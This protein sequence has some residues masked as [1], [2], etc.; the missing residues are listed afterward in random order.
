MQPRPLRP[1]SSILRQRPGRW[2]TALGRDRA[3]VRRDEPQRIRG[4]GLAPGAR[5]EH[6]IF[7]GPRTAQD[8]FVGLLA[9]QSNEARRG[10]LEAIKMSARWILPRPPRR[11]VGDDFAV[12][13]GLGLQAGK[14]AVDGGELGAPA[15]GKICLLD[16][17]A[18]S[19]LFVFGEFD[20]SPDRARKRPDGR[21]FSCDSI[22]RPARAETR[23]CR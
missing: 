22:G 5:Y 6:R 17:G 11:Q 4:R 9:P 13:L 23:R 20:K 14:R 16:I 7:A 1:R 15:G 8:F 21:L 19:V 3:L 2:A 12:R 18:Q 10:G